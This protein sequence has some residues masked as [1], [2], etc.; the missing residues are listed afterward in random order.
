MRLPAP[1]LLTAAACA[2]VGTISLLE[3]P[4]ARGIFVVGALWLIMVLVGLR[5]RWR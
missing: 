4:L 5:Y 3:F 2:I 1:V